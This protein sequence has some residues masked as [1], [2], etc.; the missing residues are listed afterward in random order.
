MQSWFDWLEVGRLAAQIYKTDQNWIFLSRDLLG[1]PRRWLFTFNDNEHRDGN[2]L[3]P[4]WIG[5]GLILLVLEGTVRLVFLRRQQARSPDGPPAAFLFLGAWMCCYHFMYY[6][7]LLGFLPLGLLFTDP[8]RYLKPLLL[9]VVP[10]R[11]S[12]ADP[13][14]I[15]YYQPALPRGAIRP[16]PWLRP[17]YGQIWVLNRMAPTLFLLLVAVQHLFPLFNWGCHYG[18][19]WDTFCLMWLWLWCSWQWLRRGEKVATSWDEG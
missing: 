8:R 7:V 18:Q 10:L 1:I 13:G 15:A 5:W 4:A 2:W 6:D 19:P 9:A 12:L 11:R 3:L 14:L 17:A 16:S